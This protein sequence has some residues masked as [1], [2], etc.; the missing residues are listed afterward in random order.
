MEP[1]LELAT[2]IVRVFL[3]VGAFWVAVY[4]VWRFAR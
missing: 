4:F 1:I 3:Y 2:D